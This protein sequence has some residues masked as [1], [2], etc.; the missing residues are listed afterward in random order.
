[1]EA[2]V[3]IA[4]FLD[5]EGKIVKLPKRRDVR[6]A[7]LLYLA[8]KFEPDRIYTEREVN[9]VCEAWHTFED[10][11]L[12]RRELVHHGLLGRKRDGSRYWRAQPSA[13]ADAQNETQP[14]TQPASTKPEP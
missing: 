8:G 9:A 10:Y 3:D 7:V 11:F 6:E 4:R 13:Q 14:D 12:L 5:S 1:M 2:R